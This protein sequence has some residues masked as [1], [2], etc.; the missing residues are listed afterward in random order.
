[1]RGL[2]LLGRPPQSN[3]TGPCCLDFNDSLSDLTWDYCFESRGSYGIASVGGDTPHLGR[4]EEAPS[5]LELF[6]RNGSDPNSMAKLSLYVHLKDKWRSP[7]PAPIPW[8]RIL[9]GQAHWPFKFEA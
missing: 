6:I 1:M 3:G 7:S 5:L 9:V 4:P 8:W 2:V